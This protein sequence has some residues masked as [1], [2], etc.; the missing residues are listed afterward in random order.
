MAAVPRSRGREV[1]RSLAVKDPSL[2]EVA[3]AMAK[4]GLE[5]EI[6]PEKR[7]PSLWFD[8]SASGYV[9]AARTEDVNRRKTL[10]EIAKLIREGREVRA[11]S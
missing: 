8:D 1:P 3:K 2:D 5:P 6:H 7:Y 9:M 11:P 10:I 4:L